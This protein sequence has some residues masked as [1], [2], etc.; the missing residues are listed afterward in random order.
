MDLYNKKD[1]NNLENEF[2]LTE[3]QFITISM[4][5]ENSESETYFDGYADVYDVTVNVHGKDGDYVS[6][7]AVITHEAL[8]FHTYGE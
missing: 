4:A 7:D 1:I 2:E 6:Y 5:G 3:G 8:Y